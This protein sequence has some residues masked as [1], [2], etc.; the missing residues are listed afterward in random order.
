MPAA[1]LDRSEAREIAA[2]LATE[3][4]RLGFSRMGI[5]PAVDTPRHERFRGWLS[6]GLAG[7]MTGWLSRHEPLR[8]HPSGLLDGVRSIVMLATDHSTVAA[9][10]RAPDEPG[11]GKLARY[12]WGDDYH[13]LLRR[14]VTELAEWIGDRVPGSRSR[15]V[16]DSAP[17]AEREF[18]RLAGL[19]WFGKNTMLIS[20]EAGSWFF[21]TAL[22]T[23]VELP[24]STPIQTDHC[25]SCTACLDACPTGALV[26]PRVLDARRC[27]SSLTIEDHGPI[28]ESLRGKLDGWIFG[29][30]IC[31]EV[32]PWNRHAP[33]T[34]EPS[35]APRGG[36]KSLPL[37]EL[38]SLD[39]E[40]FRKRFKGSPIARAKRRGL[41]R[42]AAIALGNTPDA[43]AAEPLARA[44]RDPEPVVREAAAWA[45]RRWIDRGFMADWAR[46]AL[47]QTADS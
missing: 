17:I 37:A 31:Q 34:V 12:A 26:A 13:D 4:V 27:T 24:A 9:D 16:V 18:A 22:L 21:L 39:D 15:G 25:G 35:F 36:E 42:S 3:A 41:A 29:C 8:R 23:D 43:A 38:L 30:D 46:D 20:P 2:A 11:R 32:C 44:L 33:V 40:A 47:D 10:W 5:A 7:A 45:L 14:R 1:P 28:D 19:G 6:D